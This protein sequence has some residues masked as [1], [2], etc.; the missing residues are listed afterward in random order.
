MLLAAWST[1][2]G[3]ILK[4]HL[5]WGEESNVYMNTY[6]G[7][8]WVLQAYGSRT[9]LCI[10]PAARCCRG[11]SLSL[12]LGGRVLPHWAV[13]GPTTGGNFA[14]VIP[15]PELPVGAFGAPVS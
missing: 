7:S 3:R 5:G 9:E 1:V 11:N 10:S 13:E 14:Q 4:P 15:A 6:G 8:C 2:W 12:A